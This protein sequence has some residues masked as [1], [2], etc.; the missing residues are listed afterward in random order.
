MPGD[1]P[2]PGKIRSQPGTPLACVQTPGV[3]THSE[4]IVGGSRRAS[5]G[6][7]WL[8]RVGYTE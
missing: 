2:S 8:H 7:F 3:S 5:E 6:L 4:T 1:H